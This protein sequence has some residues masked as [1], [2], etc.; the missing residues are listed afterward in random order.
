M[1]DRTDEGIRTYEHMIADMDRGNIENG[2][3]IIC[4]KIIACMDVAAI[5][6]VESRQNFR[7]V[8]DAA[9]EV[10]DSLNPLFVIR[11]RYSIESFRHFH[12]MELAGIDGRIEDVKRKSCVQF[13]NFC[14]HDKP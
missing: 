11:N 10:S 4:Q 13:F 12:G 14:H 9:E 1:V 6:T 5:I 8:P 3:V 2:D 7:I